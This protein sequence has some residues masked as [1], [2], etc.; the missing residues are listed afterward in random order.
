M[1]GFQKVSST[2]D[3]ATPHMPALLTTQIGGDTRAVGS[4]PFKTGGLV[5]SWK[6]R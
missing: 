4:M 5:T 2:R 1:V 3:P 6:W